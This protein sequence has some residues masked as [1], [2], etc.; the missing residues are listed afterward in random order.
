[1][2]HSC[3]SSGPTRSLA[4]VGAEHASRVEGGGKRT[5]GRVKEWT[6]TKRKRPMN[7]ELDMRRRK[8][9]VK[10]ASE[11]LQVGKRSGEGGN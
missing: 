8:N 1:M 9:L 5:V 2:I 3:G 6:S 4:I 7:K 11:G 10:S